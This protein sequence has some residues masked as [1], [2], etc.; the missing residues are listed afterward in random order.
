MTVVQMTPTSVGISV[1]F[2]RR[3][4]P[5][6]ARDIVCELDSPNNL[7]K[8]YGL[9][10]YQWH[11]LR[12]W[13]AFVQMTRDAAEELAGS[14][15]TTERARRKAALAIAEVGITDMAVLMGDPKVSPRDRI[16]AFAELKDIA[17]LGSK[18]QIAAASAGGGAAVGFGGPLIQIVMPNGSQL[19]VGQAEPEPKML[20]VIEGEAERIE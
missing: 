16:N 3:R 19:H 20:P 11:V 14:A 9:D 12:V 1:D 15:G 10:D 6:L 8:A 5:E 18:Q 2:I 13:P 7:A 17:V 4:G